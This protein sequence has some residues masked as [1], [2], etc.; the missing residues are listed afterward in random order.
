MCGCMCVKMY[1]GYMVLCQLVCS[2]GVCIGGVCVLTI[3]RFCGNKKV[4][5][6]LSNKYISSMNIPILLCLT[7]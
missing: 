2:R 1:G 6:D 5:T 4:I 3:F 7:I